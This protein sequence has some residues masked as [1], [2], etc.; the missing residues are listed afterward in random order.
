M[1]APTEL[2]LLLARLESFGHL[3]LGD[4]PEHPARPNR[5]LGPELARFL[6]QYPFVTRDDGYVQFLAR[7]G[8]AVFWRD[9][10]ALSLGLFGFYPDL[11]LHLT[12]GPGD[13]IESGCLTFCDLVIPP[14]G[15][16]FAADALG[17]GFGFEATGTRPW[18]VYR[19]DGHGDA[20]W[21]CASF[22]GWLRRFADCE[23][24]LDEVAPGG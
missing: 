20:Q 24:R 1:A 2:D 3:K 5:Q 4:G 17:L 8:G 16:P 18:G 22:L 14:R 19:L 6:E 7:Y 11:A 9:Q 21:F 13:I 12:K 23:G 15:N 10:D